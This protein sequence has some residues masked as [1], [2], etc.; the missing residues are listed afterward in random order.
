MT[1][2]AECPG[3]PPGSRPRGKAAPQHLDPPSRLLCPLPPESLPA[4]IACDLLGVSFPTSRLP[5]TSVSYWGVAKLRCVFLGGS[6]CAHV[7]LLSLL[8]AGA[9]PSFPVLWGCRSTAGPCCTAC[10]LTRT[11]CRV[12]A[13]ANA[14]HPR[15]RP[16]ESSISAPSLAQGLPP[17][18][19]PR[20]I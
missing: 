1:C 9:S 14:S 10:L 6:F 13:G 19:F 15:L 17:I 5:C 18:V 7:V 8:D 4:A 16:S 2:Y 3:A 12:G 20:T 11:R